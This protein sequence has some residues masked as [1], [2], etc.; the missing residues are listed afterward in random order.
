[1]HYRWRMFV[2]L[3]LQAVEDVF[4][5]TFSDPRM[6]SGL[7]TRHDH[8]QND[9]YRRRYPYTSHTR[10]GSLCDYLVMNQMLK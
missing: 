9:R 6:V 8:P 1:M 4:T 10:Y 7:I 2:Q 5:F 3:S